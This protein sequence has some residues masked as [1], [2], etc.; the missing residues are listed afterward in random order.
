MLRILLTGLAL[1]VPLAVSAQTP[2][3]GVPTER[4][5]AK[6]VK[7]AAK[8]AENAP[9]EGAATDAAKSAEPAP[10]PAP[11]AAPAPT[12]QP[13][14]AEQPAAAPAQQPA[15]P[16]EAAAAAP[17]AKEKP[18]SYLPNLFDVTVV[19]TWDTLN[20]RE[21]PDG[22]GKVVATLP[23]TAKGIQLVARDGTGK[24]GKVNV[25]EV[26]GWVALRFLKQQPGIWQPAALPQSLSCTGTEP[27][28]GLKPGKSGMVFSE[29][30]QPDRQLELRKVM[31]RGLEGE[32]TRGL[33]AGDAKGR[34]TAFIRPDQCSDGMSDRDFALAVSVIIDGQ[35]QPSRMLSGC[36]S[37]GR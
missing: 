27:F 31:D 5:I 10:A 37:I 35:D 4:P 16:A 20:V 21:S 30:D 2:A 1:S 7:D 8:P 12:P 18:P 9:V 29:P 15:P 34:V 14:P 17:A 23:A 33:I 19:E 26:S 22:Q 13:A 6:P 24:W 3:E 32:P 36:C 11:A 25:G 28:W